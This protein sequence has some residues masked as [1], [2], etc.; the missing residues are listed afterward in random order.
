[1]GALDFSVARLLLHTYCYFFN[2][3]GLIYLRFFFI[4]EPN[5][6]ILIAH[7]ALQRPRLMAFIDVGFDVDF[8]SAMR[9]SCK[10]CRVRELGA[11]AGT[12][13][14]PCG[15]FLLFLFGLG[16]ITVQKLSDN[17]R[18]GLLLQSAVNL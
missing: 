14:P 4:L 6:N 3:G 2:I 12:G 1:M 10:E 16:Q 11:G 18:N 15:L 17:L 5:N 9:S 7:D 8:L 13:F